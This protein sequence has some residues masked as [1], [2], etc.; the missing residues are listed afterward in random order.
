MSEKIVFNVSETATKM[1]ISRPTVYA[2]MNRK[3]H[4]LPSIRIG[5]RRVIPVQML[6][7]WIEEE[8]AQ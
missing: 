8:A 1:N 2:M 3:E 6:L 5:K 7:D 4:P